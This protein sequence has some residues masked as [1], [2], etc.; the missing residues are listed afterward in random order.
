MAKLAEKPRQLP[1]LDR[2]TANL[3]RRGCAKQ[4]LTGIAARSEARAISGLIDR[5]SLIRRE[6]D[7]QVLAA[8]AGFA[9]VA[10]GD[11]QRRGKG[12]KG[13]ASPVRAGVSGSK[14]P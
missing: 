14:A 2:R 1:P 13:T 8:H 12:G 7:R 11:T 10:H 9:A 6:P 3:A 4:H 5:A